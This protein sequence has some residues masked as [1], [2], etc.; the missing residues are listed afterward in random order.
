MIYTIYRTEDGAIDR[1]IACAP[2]QLDIE[3]R[4]GEAAIAGRFDSERF[5]IVGGQAAPLR[6]MAP[7]IDG[8]TV[9]NLPVPCRVTVEGTR[10]RIDD[11]V[12]EL[13]PN[14][15]GPY[16]LEIEAVGYTRCEVTLP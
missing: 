13:A 6:E 3:L 15:P 16:L 11:G 12:L 2:A 10:Y 5:R 1:V 9:A 14:L 8:Y 7:V 4:A